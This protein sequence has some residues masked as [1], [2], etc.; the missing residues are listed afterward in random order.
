MFRTLSSAGLAVALGLLLVGAAAP[1]AAAQNVVV[2]VNGDPIT[3]FDIDQRMR[4]NQLVTHKATSRDAVIEE[5]IDERVKI[6][7]GKRYKMEFSASDLDDLFAQRARLMRMSA[8][9]LT[10]MLARGGVEPGTFKSRLAAETIWQKLVQG[11]F[12][13]SFQIRDKDVLAAA[14]STE[15]DALAAKA[16]ATE[17]V[18]RPVLF[19]VTKGSENGTVD[20]RKREAE[21]LRAR[22]QGCDQGLAFARQ[23]RGVVVLEQIVKN[24]TDLPPSLREILDKTETGHLTAPETTADGV[25]VVAVCAKNEVKVDSQAFKDTKQKMLAATFEKNSRKFLQ[26]L[27]SQA[28][29]ERR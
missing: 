5:L 10:A 19:V 25:Q 24:S 3:S 22:F 15:A 18:L 7:A 9:D 6:S 20:L 21:G 13:S 28:M 16:A 14:G 17:Y 12:Q 29:I 8:Q 23:L 11:K 1:P 27:R 2:L 26:E 4:F